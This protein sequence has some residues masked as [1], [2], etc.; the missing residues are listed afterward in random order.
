MNVLVLN[1]LVLDE[2]YVE[3]LVSRMTY[4]LLGRWL[5]EPRFFLMEHVHKCY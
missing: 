3:L 2:C 4:L 1:V 5:V